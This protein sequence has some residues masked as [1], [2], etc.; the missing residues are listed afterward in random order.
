[1][2]YLARLVE[3]GRVV[4]AARFEARSLEEARK[5]A[6]ESVDWLKG[7]WAEVTEWVKPEEPLNLRETAG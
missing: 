3:L 7:Q 4:G 2:T 5:T 6:D 1:M